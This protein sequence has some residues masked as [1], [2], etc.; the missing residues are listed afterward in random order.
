[1]Q[2]FTFFLYLTG[3]TIILGLDKINNSKV[4]LQQF[5]EFKSS[6]KQS[7]QCFRKN[8]NSHQKISFQ[9]KNRHERL[10]RSFGL[11]ERERLNH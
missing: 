8:Y 1:M 9:E 6:D 7:R 4:L 3:Q 5:V 2:I 11:R 10:D